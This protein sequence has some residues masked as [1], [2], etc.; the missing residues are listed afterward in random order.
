[1]LH[2]KGTHIFAHLPHISKGFQIEPERD[3]LSLYIFLFEL[4]KPQ[5]YIS[6]DSFETQTSFFQNRYMHCSLPTIQYWNT[7]HFSIVRTS[8]FVLSNYS[9]SIYFIIFVLIIAKNCSNFLSQRT[10]Y[11]SRVP[12]LLSYLIVRNIFCD[13]VFSSLFFP[14]SFLAFSNSSILF[15]S[16]MASS[17]LRCV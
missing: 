2:Q 3:F 4:Q 11:Q 15:R 10:P 9:H 16:S 17:R 7:F 14:S 6:H 8:G 1:M 12:V 5:H 13:T